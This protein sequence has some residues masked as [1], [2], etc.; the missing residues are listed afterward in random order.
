MSNRYGIR[1]RPSAHQRSAKS[2]IET[3]PDQI[4]PGNKTT[5]DDGNR[6]PFDTLAVTKAIQNSPQNTPSNTGSEDSNSNNINSN[7]VKATWF[8][9]IS[10]LGYC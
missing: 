6:P 8:Q 2:D 3:M 4:A 5:E 10:L 9:A 1:L 7:I